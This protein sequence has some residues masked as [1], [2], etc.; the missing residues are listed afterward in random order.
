MEPSAF[1]PP[2]TARRVERRWRLKKRSR[3][4]YGPRANSGS[5]RKVSCDRVIPSLNQGLL[6][7]QLAWQELLIF[8]PSGSA[9]LSRTRKD[10][11]NAGRLRG[12]RGR[13]REKELR[14]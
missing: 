12:D 8:F 14:E 2:A 6:P 11:A 13:L 4:R 10:R 1:A 3:E 9:A 7:R 5:T